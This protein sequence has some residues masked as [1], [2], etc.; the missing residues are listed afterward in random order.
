L[1]NLSSNTI[2]SSLKAEVD[3]LLLESEDAATVRE[4]GAFDRIAQ[5]FADRIVLF[6]A[7]GMGRRMLAGLRRVGIV[8][9]A[10]A[11]NNRGAHGTEIEGIPVLSPSEAAERYG[12]NATFVITIWSTFAKDR[13]QERIQQQQGLGCERVVPAGFLCWRYPE[14]FL[15]FFP[16]DLPHKVLPHASEIRAALDVFDEPQSRREFVA[17]LRFRLLLDFDRMGS[18]NGADAYFQTGLFELK[19]DEVFVDCGAFDGDTI[20]EFLRTRGHAFREL[21]AFEPDKLNLRALQARID[22][23]P[24]E[25]H[26]KITVFPHALGAEPGVVCFSSSG[27]DQSKIGAGTESVQLVT[28]DDSLEKRY[29]SYIKFDIEGAEPG[30]LMG[31]RRTIERDR[32]IL[33]V[34]AYHEQSHLWEVPLLL[35]RIC[36]DYRFYLRPHGAEGWDLVCYAVPI[37]RCIQ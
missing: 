29:P 24:G 6:G 19:P 9:L 37:E 32:P 35:A 31:A 5:P 10:F 33:A 13:M 25:L 8:P 11:D 30:A 16:M 12:R 7:G 21:I 18:P 15:P 23:L 17:Q 1:R 20:A 14:I 3:E 36:A 2:D 28:L 22:K 26:P 4:R 34:S 27:S